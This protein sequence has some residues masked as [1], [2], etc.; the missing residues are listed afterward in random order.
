M[1]ARLDA[2][3]INSQLRIAALGAEPLDADEERALARAARS[4]NAR[5]FDRLVRA[6]LRLV[7][8]MVAEHPS[9]GAP[10]S[11][12]T[13]EGMLGLVCAARRFDPDRGVRLATY[14]THWIRAYLRRYTLRTRRIVGP[15]STRVGRAVLFNLGRAERD[16][17]QLL[18]TA[19]TR[20]ALAEY[21]GASV[22]E[23]AEAQQAL[24]ARDAGIHGGEGL[25][26]DSIEPISPDPSPELVLTEAE[27]RRRA[28]ALLRRGF[29]T[30]GARERTIL[31]SR[32]LQAEPSSLDELGRSLGISRERVRQLEARG[33]ERLRR[34]VLRSVA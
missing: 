9:Y 34:A 32:H 29:T 25:I 26:V 2:H 17:A 6:H 33:Y 7:F 18:G 4:G 24:R 20:E 21:L 8:A 28:A 23:V 13:A 12:L 10:T 5:A 31:R 19:P 22:D 15:P 27:A 3:S 16:L 14:A 30:L 1:E 11:D